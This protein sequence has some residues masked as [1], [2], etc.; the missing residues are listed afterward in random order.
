MKGYDFAARA[1]LRPAQNC[2]RQTRLVE[3][4][5]RR[6]FAMD[7]SAALARALAQAFV[8]GALDPDGMTERGAALLGRRWRW[9]RPLAERICRHFQDR[10]RPRQMAV[11]RRLLSD[12]GFLR[13]C[14][15]EEVTVS[16]SIGIV[17]GMAPMSAAADWNVPVLRTAGELADWLELTIGQLDWFADRRQWEARQHGPRLQHYIY[18]PL[19]KRFGQVRLI[20]A[21]KPRLKAMQRRILGEILQQIPVHQAAHGFRRG[22]SIRSFASPHVGRRVV[23]RIDLQDFFPSINRAQVEAIFRAAGY[24]E[25]VAAL[26]TGLCTNSAPRE[27]WTDLHL[28]RAGRLGHAPLLYER[29]HLPQG[30]PTS[31]ALANLCAYRLDCRLTGL[32]AAAGATY[33]RYADDL[34]FSGDVTFQRAVGRFQL[35]VCA[36]AMEEG[37]AVHHRKTRIMRRGVRQQLAGVVVNER[38]NVR[39]SDY[40]RLKAILTNCARRGVADQNRSGCRDFRA[41][42]L[43]RIA[44]VELLNPARSARL[45][46]LFEQ[47]V[48]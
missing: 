43:G 16:G 27:V 48:W 42:V 35:H 30:A 29:P 26:L 25:H 10:P 23:L 46:R 47:I 34:A 22:R 5:C 17:P 3:I 14:E 4:S 37:F 9:L 6:Y 38:M 11:A 12:R 40:D 19:S 15:A 28:P 8:A 2:S 45:R 20:E 7:P 18:R 13:A 36:T 33:T 21:P 32:A 1:A 41:H 39:R 31:P 44:H 24:P